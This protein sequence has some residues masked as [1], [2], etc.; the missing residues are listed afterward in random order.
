MIRMIARYSVKAGRTAQVE[1]A[2]R[3]FVDA[4]A[5]NEPATFYQAYRI[6]EG[7]E[8]FH[9]MAFPDEAAESTHR[10][11]AYTTQFVDALY[12]ECVQEPDFARLTLVK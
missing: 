3:T 9:L 6:G 2:I 11:A 12:P 4:V 5:A 7:N 8:F 10:H 1:A